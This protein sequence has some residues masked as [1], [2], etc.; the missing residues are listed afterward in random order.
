MSA[1]KQGATFTFSI[2][3]LTGRTYSVEMSTNLLNWNTATNITLTNG[4]AQISRPMTGS[5]QFY[6]TR[7]LP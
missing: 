4:T 5:R 7:L 2:Q 6:R 1:R 3:G